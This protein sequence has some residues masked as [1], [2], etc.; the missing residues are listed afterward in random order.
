MI[1]ARNA[2][3]AT[4]GCDHP[5]V[6]SDM[7]HRVEYENGG[8]TSEGNLDPA[9]HG[10]CHRLKQNERWQVIKTGPRETV[11]IGPSGRKRVVRPTRYLIM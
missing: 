9:T 5:A 6:T 4:P 2:T 1:E 7:E 3:C 8:K 11:W 10:H